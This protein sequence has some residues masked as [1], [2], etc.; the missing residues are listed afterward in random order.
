MAHCVHYGACGGCAMDER[1]GID[2]SAVLAAALAKAGFVNA[3]VAPL[4]E[5]PLHT[6][7]RVDLAAAR[8]DGGVALGLHRARAVQVV[9][10]REC[11]LLDARIMQLLPPL[12]VL[13]RG[14]DG[15]RAGAAVLINL[16]DTG[17][18]V[19]LRLDGAVS[20]AD[21]RKLIAFAQANNVQRI[22]VARG[23][24]PAEPVAILAP[25]VLTLS[26][27]AVQP[28][29][30][31]F[32]QPSRDGEAAIVSAMLAG[33]PKLAAKARVVEL[34]AGIGT[35]TFALA[36]HCRVEAYEGAED[37]VAAHEVA[38][39]EHNLAGK[40][41]LYHRDLT[42]RPLQVAEL[43]GRAAIVLDPPYAGA[44]RQLP[45]IAASGVGRV[46]YVSC[47][48]NALAA[49]AI[50]LRRAG[51]AVLNATPIDQFPYSENLESVVV[52]GKS[53]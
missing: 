1:A 49:D 36:R 8:S 34:Y 41:M 46:I 38:I 14:L 45:A 15:L 5:V 42:R 20:Q 52:F 33:L 4:I 48:P 24:E 44:A 11:V 16:L 23:D 6:R 17:A 43:S 25:P 31:A 21:R 47:N 2:K 28:P 26:G 37:A 19:L 50:V 12:R 13:L 39:R 53:T 30:G 3:P 22:S 32:L 29:P 7:R 18:D 51:Y 40:I 27:I 10:M 35:L 9:D